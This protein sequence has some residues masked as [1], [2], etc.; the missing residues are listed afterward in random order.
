[1]HVCMH[2]CTFVCMNLVHVFYVFCVTCVCESS[3]WQAS[4]MGL[5]C[6]CYLEKKGQKR[7]SDIT[8]DPG[9]H[10]PQRPCAQGQTRAKQDQ[11]QA[12][13]PG[14]NRTRSAG[15]ATAHGRRVGSSV[16]P[17]HCWG[18]VAPCQEC[19]LHG[20]RGTIVAQRPANSA[21]IRQLKHTVVVTRV[22]VRSHSV[23]EQNSTHSRKSMQPAS[24]RPHAYI[25]TAQPT[26]PMSLPHIDATSRHQHASWFTR[27][28]K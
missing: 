9:G 22:K 15:G 27:A 16:L 21:S 19:C 2:S 17:N 10:W 5:W 25:P 23:E 11:A 1:M 12:S 6:M 13:A 24:H 8:P 7:R 20:C 18:A 3:H 14:Q 4:C 26:Q 28:L